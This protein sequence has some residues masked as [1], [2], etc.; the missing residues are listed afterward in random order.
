MKQ[1]TSFKGQ[2]VWNDSMKPWPMFYGKRY[3]SDSTGKCDKYTNHQPCAAVNGTGTDTCC[4]MTGIPP[5]TLRHGRP[6]GGRPAPPCFF[7]PPVLLPSDSLPS[8]SSMLLHPPRGALF[9]ENRPPG[10]P[11]KAFGCRA[12]LVCDI[13]G[14]ELTRMPGLLSG[15]WYRLIP[16]T[17][18]WGGPHGGP[19]G[20]TSK[21]R[22]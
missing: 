7:L 5:S 11:A 15:D 8:A 14:F 6:A 18:L 19:P 3:M 10:P 2:G 16:T 1:G 9:R 4:R 21:E 22:T 13:G 20:N 12:L 17:G